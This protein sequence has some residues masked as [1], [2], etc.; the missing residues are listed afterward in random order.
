MPTLHYAKAKRIKFPYAEKRVAGPFETRS[1]AFAAAKRLR[2]KYPDCNV[3]PEAR[4]LNLK[5]AARLLG[6]AQIEE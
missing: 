2:E 3:M 5:D 1:E 6:G 4:H